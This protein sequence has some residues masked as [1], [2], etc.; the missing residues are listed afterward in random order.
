MKTWKTQEKIGQTNQKKNSKAVLL[1]GPP[2][3]GKTTAATVISKSL[4][5][6]CIIQNASNQRNKASVNTML[7]GLKDNQTLGHF[8]ARKN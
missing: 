7:T 1:S 3:I 4:G 8:L 6:D 2:G 5:Y